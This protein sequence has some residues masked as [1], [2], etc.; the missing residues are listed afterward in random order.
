MDRKGLNQSGLLGTKPAGTGFPGKWLGDS[1]LLYVLS[2]QGA[3]GEDWSPAQSSVCR[4]PSLFIS[5]LLGKFKGQ[6][7]RGRCGT[8]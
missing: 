8:Y 5:A 4:S 3:C 7:G 2:G 1:I 6:T